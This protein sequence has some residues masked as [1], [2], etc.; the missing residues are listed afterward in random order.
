MHSQTSH[1]PHLLHS[2][3]QVV[4]NNYLYHAH[5]GTQMGG[6]VLKKVLSKQLAYLAGGLEEDK[7]P[8]LT[9]PDVGLRLL[10]AKEAQADLTT[11]ILYIKTLLR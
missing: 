10:D 5:T 7:H 9:I 8:I 4:Y 1:T 6:D 2:R 11:T 3:Y